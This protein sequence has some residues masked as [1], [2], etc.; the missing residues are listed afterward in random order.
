MASKE[1]EETTY[2][3]EAHRIYAAWFYPTSM[4]LVSLQPG[5]EKPGRWTHIADENE[6]SVLVQQACLVLRMQAEHGY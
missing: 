5:A 4:R 2:Q 1:T 6:Q 3:R